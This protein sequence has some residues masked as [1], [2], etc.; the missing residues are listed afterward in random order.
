MAEPLL[1]ILEKSSIIFVNKYINNFLSIITSLTL[2]RIN[3]W[4]IIPVTASSGNM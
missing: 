1:C 3:A 4:F 2:I